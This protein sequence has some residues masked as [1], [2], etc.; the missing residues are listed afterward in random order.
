MVQA[1]KKSIYAVVGHRYVTDEELI[2]VFTGLESLLNS[3]L[4]TYQSSDLREDVSLTPNNFLHGQMGGKFAPKSVKT[5]IFHLR[6]TWRK[7]QDI[8]KKVWRR[9][10]KEGVSALLPADQSGL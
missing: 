5:T 2:T 10:L 4:L 8:I 7:G 1:D 9:W 3:R 6:Q